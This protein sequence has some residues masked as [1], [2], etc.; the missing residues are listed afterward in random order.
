MFRNNDLYPLIC[1]QNTPIPFIL[2]VSFQNL[3]AWLS[4]TKLHLYHKI[5]MILFITHC[6]SLDME[7]IYVVAILNYNKNKN[8]SGY[9]NDKISLVVKE[10]DYETK[11]VIWLVE[12]QD[13]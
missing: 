7:I 4:T 6:F 13:F 10:N 12:S 1:K 5:L 8:K 2:I 11:F 3:I 9:F